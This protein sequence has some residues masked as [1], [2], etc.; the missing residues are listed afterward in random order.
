VERDQNLSE[1]R[2]PEPRRLKRSSIKTLLQG[3][4]MAEILRDG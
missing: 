3:V 4:S 1:K 2:L